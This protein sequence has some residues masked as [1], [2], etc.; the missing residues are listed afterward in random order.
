[1]SLRKGRISPDAEVVDP[2]AEI[3]DRP[4]RRDKPQQ[5]EAERGL[6]RA[7]FTDNAKRL[8][9]PNHRIDAIDCLDM[10]DV[11]RKKPRLIG[12]QTFSPL[13]SMTTGSARVGLGRLSPWARPKA[14]SAYRDAGDCRRFLRVGPASTILPCCMTQT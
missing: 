11:L 8:S 12:N 5:S 9:G 10:P 7:R 2:L 14:A 6:P 1:M 4:F 13:V 3:D